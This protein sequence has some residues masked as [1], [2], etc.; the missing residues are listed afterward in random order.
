MHI[1]APLLTWISGGRRF[2]L[3]PRLAKSIEFATLDLPSRAEKPQSLARLGKSKE[4]TPPT[5]QVELRNLHLSPDLP[6]RKSPPKATSQV[7]K[8]KSRRQRQPG[9]H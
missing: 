4:T 2:G 6:S 1:C 8:E 5:C 3:R 9:F 7:Q